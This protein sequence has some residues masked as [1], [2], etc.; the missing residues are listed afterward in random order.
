VA[1]ESF[2]AALEALATN[3]GNMTLTQNVEYTSEA[4]IN[5]EPGQTLD[6]NGKTLTMSGAANS[7][8]STGAVIDSTE[9]GALIVIEQD[10][11]QAMVSFA[12]NNPQLPLY[13]TENGGYRFYTASTINKGTQGS[14]DYVRFGMHLDV[15]DF[16]LLKQVDNGGAVVTFELFSDELKDGSVSRIFDASILKLYADNVGANTVLVLGVSGMNKLQDKTSLIVEAR[17]ESAG[18]VKSVTIQ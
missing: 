5:I 13:D 10:R 8:I 11:T 18:V 3:G 16:A 4:Y 15:T 14:G 9:G 1:Y 17:I 7:I 6:L 12:A 2:D